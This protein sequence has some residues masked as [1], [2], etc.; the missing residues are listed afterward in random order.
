MKNHRHLLKGF[1][2]YLIVLVMVFANLSALFGSTRVAAT[3]STA[4]IVYPNPGSVQLD[5]T[6]TGL[7]GGIYEITLNLSGVPLV[8]STD[9]VLV[10]DISTSMAGT[11]ITAAK[12]AAK[13]FIDAILGQNQGHRIAIVSFA[14]T[15][16][17]SM[18]F[19]QDAAA[20]KNT[21]TNLVASG[22]THLEGGIYTAT[23]LLSASSLA[24]NNKAIVVLGDGIPT[25]GYQFT[26]VY[27]GP[28]SAT[29]NNH[30][31]CKVSVSTT[32]IANNSLFTGRYV[33]DTGTNLTANTTNMTFSKT[34]A[35][36]GTC[37]NGAT[38]TG[39]FTKTYSLEDS[40]NWQANRAKA[41][42]YSVFSIGLEVNSTGARVLQAIQNSG[43]YD[44]ASADLSN[45]YT[46]IA[47][48]IVYAARS[49]IITDKIG[50]DFEFVAISDGYTALDATYDSSTRIL[51]WNVGNVGASP[52]ILKYT[53]RIHAG[54]PSGEYPTNEYATVSYTDI[55][56]TPQDGTFPK[57]IVVVSN[58][59][60]VASNKSITVLEG[61]AVTSFVS[62]TDPEGDMLTYVMIDGPINGIITFNTDGSFIYTH[63][64]T[65]TSSDSFTYKANDGLYNSNVATV[66]ISVTPKNDA[67]S[68]LDDSFTV[69]ENG[70]HNGQLTATDPD[71][72]SFTFSAIDLPDNGTLTL[73]LDG[74][75]TYVH[76]GSA[77]TT[78]SFTYRANDGDLDSNIA[79]ISITV[80]PDNGT[81]V[82]DDDAFTLPKGSTHTGTLSALDPKGKTLTFTVK[83]NPTHGS[84]TLNANGAYS[85]THNGD[86]STTDSFTFTVSNGS[87]TSAVATVTITVTPVN[88]APTTLPETITVNEGGSINDKVEGL[89]VDGDP[90]TFSL[91][92]NVIHG[93]L[94][95]NPNGTYTYTHD[96]SETISDTFKF[97]V[98]DGKAYSEVRTA[99]IVINPINDAPVAKNGAVTTAFETPITRNIHNLITDKDSANW[100]LTLVGDV[101]HG[102]LVFNAD[103]SYTYTPDAGFSGDDVFTFKGNDGTLDSNL[104]TYTI[105]VAEEGIV[106]DPNIAPVAS[107][108]SIDTEF[109][110]AVSGNL[111]DLI[112]DVDGTEWELFLV[113][114]PTHGTLSL[115]LDGTY[116]YTPQAGF[117]GLDT[118]T[119]KA[120][121]GELD[122][123]IATFTISVAEEVIIDD[124]ETP[125]S[126]LSYW[127]VFLLGLLLIIIF[128]LRPNLK[129]V[130]VDKAGNEKVI[131]RHVFANGDD[132]LSVDLNDKNVTGLVNI[133]LVVYKQLVKREQGQKITFNLFN[134]P[135]KTI[136]IP[137]DMKE[138]IEDK[139]TL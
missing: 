64:G 127:W 60:P 107:N 80:T 52:M 123:N 25:K 86:S 24:A 58:L 92:G 119:F 67:P 137:E 100:T 98:Y 34:F 110:T 70:T 53:L 36:S 130:L 43:Y 111:H 101:T 132:D 17:L 97:K 117:S 41:L 75:Y 82:A 15:P 76:D 44:A 39:S 128:F 32:D 134:K 68:V 103:G 54:L 42:G 121:D 113:S 116:T 135:V 73:N 138:K 114:S 87:S 95:L 19:S 59:V 20:L 77:T 27:T 88:N 131:R 18:T 122:S 91:T 4:S 96:G 31:V 26:P 5:K 61:E 33:F 35:I 14:D 85:Y 71:G 90:L 37:S 55:N 12:N 22:Y 81:P 69:F 10:M 13:N 106:I 23:E 8:K 29:L 129:Y 89:D 120:N 2:K 115:N 6:E 133:D 136:A 38:A 79:T 47:S 11:K 3:S 125:L 72:S 62:A 99:T 57:P 104:A 105:T 51:T 74:S 50:D 65:E 56:D 49:A 84:L 30:N 112:T 28:V 108:G 16:T 45:I 9:I 66:S 124:P 126:P 102:T 21:I 83:T 40:V 7:G 78:D 63:N 93:T 94:V 118:F 139:I 1:A 48:Q 46:A 109:E